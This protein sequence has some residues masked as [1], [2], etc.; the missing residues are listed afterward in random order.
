MGSDVS[1]FFL[2]S[3]L[4]NSFCILILILI[5]FY[6]VF[7]GYYKLYAYS[8]SLLG[9][10][11]L[12]FA[13]SGVDY[14][15]LVPVL[16]IFFVVSIADFYNYVIGVTTLSDFEKIIRNTVLVFPFLF[17]LSKASIKPIC[18][19][20]VGT[21]LFLVTL[22]FVLLQINGLYA[23]GASHYDFIHP[24]LWFNK[25]SFSAAV[26][27]FFAL[28]VG[29]SFYIEGRCARFLLLTSYF[30][31]FMILYLTQARGP[32]LAFFLISI[33]IVF[34]SIKPF[35]TSRR[36]LVLCSI[37]FFAIGFVF[38]Y[39]AFGDKISIGKGELVEH[40]E[41]GSQYT[42]VSIRLDTWQLA[43]DVFKQG[44]LWGA[45][46]Q[47][48][49]VAKKEIV[50]SGKYPEYILNY[51]THSEYFMTL[52]RGG[53]VGIF[54]LLWMLFFPVFHL[55][56]VGVLYRNMYPLLLVVGSFMIIGITSATIRNNIGANS[57]LLCLL[58][59]YFFSYK[60]FSRESV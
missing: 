30:S 15:P 29:I 40:I 16:S 12:F 27:I 3:S 53:V 54:G 26:V 5:A 46:T 4:A 45:G 23:Q 60:Y 33:C 32:L 22:F 42:S 59:A 38:I 24:G 25:G 8:V 9:M 20:L 35:F 51:H 18:L 44:P 48:A 56:S 14:K 36:S 31:V 7:P 39:S 37:L 58:F 28:F 57:F 10:L 17:F 52:E 6:F 41:S 2:R 13:R 1:N 11:G 34:F 49:S 50:D 21:L 19:M 47:G 55:K 43:W